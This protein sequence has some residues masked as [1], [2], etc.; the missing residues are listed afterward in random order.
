VTM[1][2]AASASDR[3]AS[4]KSLIANFFMRLSC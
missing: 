2:A 1:G 3:M 4:V